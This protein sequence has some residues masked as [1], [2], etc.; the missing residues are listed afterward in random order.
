MNDRVPYDPT[1]NPRYL[2]DEVVQPERDQA[3]LVQAQE[4]LK[5]VSNLRGLLESEIW[6]TLDRYLR[7]ELERITERLVAYDS[8]LS[9]ME[10]VAQARGYRHAL[11]RILDELPETLELAERALIEQITEQS[12]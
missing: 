11:W 9:T 10:Q 8:A 1:L 3:A 2:G 5:E 4:R 6:H 12:G 7:P